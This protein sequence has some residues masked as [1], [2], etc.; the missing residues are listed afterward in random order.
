M[1][2]LKGIKEFSSMLLSMIHVRK[3]MLDT[4][5]FADIEVL[6]RVLGSCARHA[7]LS[8]VHIKGAVVTDAPQPNQ[9]CLGLTCRGQWC[10]QMHAAKYNQNTKQGGETPVFGL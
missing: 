5:G 8:H 6:R 9:L 4:V 7:L 3:V 1:V 2:F 10:K